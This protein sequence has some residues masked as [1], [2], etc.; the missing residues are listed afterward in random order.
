MNHTEFLAHLKRMPHENPSAALAIGFVIANMDDLRAAAD[1]A[2]DKREFWLSLLN[3]LTGVMHAAIGP[4]A[5]RRVR[6][7]VFAIG[8]DAEVMVEAGRATKQ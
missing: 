3:F 6:G 4:E 2:P 8:N 7:E 1:D 5:A